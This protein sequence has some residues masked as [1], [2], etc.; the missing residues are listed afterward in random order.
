MLSQ[1][2]CNTYNIHFELEENPMSAQCK[3]QKYMKMFTTV[4]KECME[5]Q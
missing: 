5:T 1:M 2:T 3:K 4:S